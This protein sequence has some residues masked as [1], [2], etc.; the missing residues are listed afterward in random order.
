MV[1]H[2]FSSQIDGNACQNLLWTAGMLTVGPLHPNKP[3]QRPPASLQRPIWP[4]EFLKLVFHTFWA[5]LQFFWRKNLWVSTTFGF[6][7]SFHLAR[8]FN[9]HYIKGNPWVYH[10]PLGLS[11]PPCFGG[12][13]RRRRRENFGDLGSF[14]ID[15]LHKIDEL[16]T[17]SSKK[18]APAARLPWNIH[19]W[20]LKYGKSSQNPPNRPRKI[21]LFTPSPWVYPPSFWRGSEMG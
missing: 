3:A 18:F 10:P 9:T 14:F 15:F 7:Y 20:A 17:K 5:D 11:P 12:G 13:R 8:F 6:F 19:F 4:P 1:F 16:D 2:I 21:T